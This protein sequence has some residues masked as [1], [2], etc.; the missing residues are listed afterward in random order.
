MGVALGIFFVPA[1]KPEAIPK[2]DKVIGTRIATVSHPPGR[3]TRLIS[4][5]FFGAKMLMTR[6]AAAS[7]TGH[8]PQRSVTAK[9]GVGQRRAACRT[10]YFEMSRPRLMVE[11][12]ICAAIRAM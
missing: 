6:S 4:G 9:A 5:K 1:Q 2:L 10:A 7:W 3:S 8:S 11:P 12:G